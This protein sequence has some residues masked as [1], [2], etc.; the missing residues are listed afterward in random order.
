MPSERDPDSEFENEVARAVASCGYQVVPQVG[1]AGFYV[2]LAVVDPELPGR[3]LLGIECDG[4]SY[5][6]SRSARDRDRLRQ[7]VLEDRGWIIHRIWSTDWFNRPDDQLR[8][9]VAAID[10]AKVEWA[11]RDNANRDCSDQAESP[12]TKCAIEREDGE[13]EEEE[14]DCDATDL[15]RPYVEAS[16]DIILADDI[17][18]ASTP[19]L[20]NI[21]R[22]IVRI[23]GPI[24]QDEIARRITQLWGLRRAG[25]RIA[26]AVDQAICH[27]TYSKR[28]DQ[29]GVFLSS[30]E[31]DQVPVRDRSNVSSQTLRKPDML[32]PA[33]IRSA[34]LTIAQV[35]LGV[36]REEAVAETSRLFGFRTTSSQLREVISDEVDYLVEK[37]LLERRNG[38]LYH[39]QANNNLVGR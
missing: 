11:R 31:Q 35:H 9:T 37:E 7:Q 39:G 28:I 18:N 27:A 30:G 3:F 13:E 32:P 19:Q 34:I 16:F 12:P 24:H 10:N 21:V 6:S 36:A 33:E 8:K 4:A 38:K 20:A 14:A 25:S 2:D 1:V 5:H 17:H 23:E 26:Q 22:R 29:D 15:S